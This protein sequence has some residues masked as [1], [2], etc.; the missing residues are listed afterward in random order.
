[1]NPEKTMDRRTFYLTFIYGLWALMG[2]VMAVLGGVYLLWPPPVKKQEEWI[3]AGTLAQVP[4]KSPEE[5]VFRRNR[6]DGWKLISEKA[7]AWVVKLSDRQ[8]VAYSPKCPHLG[9]AYHWDRQNQD[10]LCPC[11]ASTFTLE[12][13]VISGPAQRPLDR[14][15]IKVEG[16][17]LFLGRVRRS[18]ETSG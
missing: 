4:V 3:E 10:F 13:E 6:Y 9:C 14:Y 11:H 16:D 7:T 17:K 18:E 2:A 15:E 12:G 1:M 8:V 5:F